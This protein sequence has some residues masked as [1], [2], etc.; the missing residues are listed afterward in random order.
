MLA[1]CR[2]IWWHLAIWYV[3]YTSVW[4][5]QKRSSQSEYVNAT[6]GGGAGGRRANSDPVWDAMCRKCWLQYP[7]TS[8]SP[9]VSLL[10]DNRLTIH[11]P[12]P[13]HLSFSHLFPP[14]SILFTL[15]EAPTWSC[16]VADAI[17]DCSI[18]PL[19]SVTIHHFI[20]SSLPPSSSFSPSLALSLYLFVYL[21]KERFDM[22]KRWSWCCFN[23]IAT[24]H[25][26]CQ[27]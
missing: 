5:Q 22:K 4:L 18:P 11:P 25:P 20:R 19:L 17:S 23:A 14:L 15:G 21:P 12:P 24:S 8:I 9:N 6:R 2:R 3:I 13:H 26:S 1:S 27:S 16:G 10:D 7:A